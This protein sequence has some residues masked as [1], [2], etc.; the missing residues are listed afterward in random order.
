M[1]LEDIV[2]HVVPRR[3]LI[4]GV[5]AYTDLIYRCVNK[6]YRKSGA[7]FQRHGLASLAQETAGERVIDDDSFALFQALAQ[8][9]HCDRARLF[10]H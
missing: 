7:K 10:S 4:V 9:I 2:P 8:S 3:A 1:V 5:A 6:N